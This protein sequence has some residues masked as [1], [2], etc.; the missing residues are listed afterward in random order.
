LAWLRNWLGVMSGI[1]AMTGVR[2]TAM[3]SNM[4]PIEAMN[5]GSA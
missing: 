3:A 5:R 1:K 2:N 4:A